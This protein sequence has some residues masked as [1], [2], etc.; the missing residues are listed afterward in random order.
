MG[1]KHLTSYYDAF[2]TK[3][4]NKDSFLVDLSRMTLFHSVNFIYYTQHFVVMTNRAKNMCPSLFMIE[5][6]TT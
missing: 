1:K 3:Q 5:T 2:P 4:N 6:S